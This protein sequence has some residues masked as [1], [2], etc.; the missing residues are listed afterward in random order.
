MMLHPDGLNEWCE[1]MAPTDKT[2]APLELVVLAWSV[3]ALVGVGPLV[4]WLL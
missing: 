4:W 1:H 2:P 3:V